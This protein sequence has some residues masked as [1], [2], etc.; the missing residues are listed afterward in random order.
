MFQ[1]LINIFLKDTITEETT[2]GYFSKPESRE[3]LLST[4]QNRRNK[5]K[6]WNV[7]FYI[8]T[9]FEVGKITIRDVLKKKYKLKN[10]YTFYH[11][12]WV[13]IFDI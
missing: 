1:L 8:N 10:I 12:Q 13:Y 6:K 9:D 2:D 3:S 5:K 7:W 4:P 11:R